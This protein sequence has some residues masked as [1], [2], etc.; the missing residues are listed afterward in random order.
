L[1]VV[2]ERGKR[3]DRDGSLTDTS[4]AWAT[5]GMMAL[6]GRADGPALGGPMALVDGVTA[7]ADDIALRSG[8]LGRPVVVD[9]LALM[10]ERAATIGLHRHGAVSCGGTSRLMP[11]R[12]GW[13]AA[14]LA[15]PSDW[16]LMAALLELPA[17]VGPG[18]WV[19]VERAVANLAGDV[20]GSRSELLGIPVS[21]LGE[22]SA[23]P[24]IRKGPAEMAHGIRSRPIRPASRRR[25]CADLI[26]ADL[27]A[28]WAGPLVGRILRLT[29]AWVVK[30]ESRSRPD[31]ARRGSPAFFRLLNGGKESVVLDFTTE[32][33][34]RRLNEVVAQVDVVITSSRPRAM[35]QL[36][37]DVDALVRDGRPQ[38][39][40]MISGYGP[41]VVGPGRAAFGDDAAVAG[42]LVAW[43]RGG[44][45]FC[46]DAVA[47]PLCGLAATAAVLAA[48]ERDEA[49]VVEASMADI[50]GGMSGAALEVEGLTPAAP[51]VGGLPPSPPV[52]EF[53]ADTG[54][55]LAVLGI[56]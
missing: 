46:G 31:G 35:E 6:T 13:M 44:P 34:R 14:T 52:A 28:L 43:D 40:L 1:R 19:T 4:T 33:G 3:S 48:L 10:G 17:P 49:S 15:R 30:I 36:G 2:V 12:D 9:P 47:D 39:W 38:V 8:R 23:P 24:E 42:G 16:E 54:P 18:D 45:T 55:F 51:H 5:S 41:G 56:R 22:R 53:G 32:D 50:A 37:L 29:G 20:L 26:V 7:L 11:S 27:S 21:V 25:S